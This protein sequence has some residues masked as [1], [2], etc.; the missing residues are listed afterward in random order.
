[1]IAGVITTSDR[2]FRGEREDDSG[3]VLLKILEEQN[4][5]RDIKYKL[6]PD[7]KEMIREAILEFTKDCNLILTTGGTG[8]SPR[9]L[10]PEV[11]RELIEKEVPGIPEEMRRKSREITPHAILSRSVAGIRGKCLIINLPG[12]PHGAKENLE[13]IIN[14]I[15]HA[16]KLIRGEVKD[17]REE[18]GSVH[19]KALSK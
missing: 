1:L 12:S 17:C 14:V 16:L 8:I 18:V 5:F 3:P 13:A 19:N 6:V 9:D 15:P 11:T 4:W 10:T 2:G 7:E